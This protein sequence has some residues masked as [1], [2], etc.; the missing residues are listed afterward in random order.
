MTG[1]VWL[2]A[3]EEVDAA[4][5][6]QLLRC[7]VEVSNAG[8]AV[9]F[10]FPPV[11][12]AQVRPV[13]SALLDGL[14]PKGTHLLVAVEDGRLLGW[15]TLVLSEAPLVRHWAR[16]MRVQTALAARGQGVGAALVREAARS[17]AALG[18]EHLVIEVRG[19]TGLEGFYARLGWQEFGRHPRALRLS[20]QDV[21]D[22][23]LMRLPLRPP[24]P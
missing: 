7:W 8:G 11:D 13:L 18:L 2:R 16:V 4:L 10:P 12:A 24:A 22:E 6:A 21:R 17:G 5:R 9:G 1:L 15:L 19:G 23:V 20:E 3:P 14:E